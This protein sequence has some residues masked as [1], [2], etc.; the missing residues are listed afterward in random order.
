MDALIQDL[1]YATRS[2]FR[3][4]G[5]TTVAILT[6]TLGVGA[7]TAIFSVADGLI[8]HPLRGVESEGLAIVAV[9]QK[10]P[11]AAADY[12]DWTRLSH[13]FDELAAYRQR[14]ATLTGI[15]QPE[16]VYATEATP[17]FFSVI[18]TET[19]AGR[20]FSN[21]GEDADASVVLSHGFWQRRFG[22]DPHVIG[23][24]VDV[25]GRARTIIGIM[26]K[27]F[28]VPVPT[29]I[30]LPLSLTPADRAKRDA[31]ILRVVGRLK[32]AVTIDAAQTE[33][34]TIGRQ[35][36]ASYPTTNT[37]RRP[38]VM[39]LRE[40]VQGTITR[41]A[42]FLLLSLV[43]VV[44]L[45]ACANVAGLQL[46]RAS[47][48]AREVGLRMALGASRWRVAQ[49]V[50]A[51]T[52][53][54]AIV[55]GAISMIVASFCINLLLRSMPG[56]IARLIPGFTHIRV[57]GRAI[58]FATLVTFASGIVAA[59]AP[60]LRL[61]RT[62]PGESLKESPGSGV[63][64]SR[65]RLRS[66]FVVAQVAVAFVMLVVS[67]L[68]VSGLRGLFRLQDVHD[69]AH[70]LVLSL[71]L[72]SARY[73]DAESR[74][75]F[76]R[77]VVDRFG[78]LP[79]VQL[80][81]SF[82]TIPLSNNGVA[83]AAVDIEG[84]PVSAS[85]PRPNAVVQRVSADY[86]ALMRIP[87]QQG[88]VLNSADRADA[89][90]VV[91]ISESL[92]KRYWPGQDAIGRRVTIGTT[93]AVRWS[94]VVGVV[95]NVLYD[96]TNRVPEPTIYFPV[97]QTPPTAAQIAL[98]V[99]GDPNSFIEPA[100]RE[101]A[102][103][104]PLLPAFDVM[105]LSDAIHQSLVGNP[106]M[107]TMMGMLGGLA[108]IIAVVGL[109]GVISYLVSARTREFGVRLALGARR[110]DIFAVVMLRSASLAAIGI[111]LG[112]LLSIAMSRVVRGVVFGAG[113]S[114]PLVWLEVACVLA[115]VMLFATYVPAHRAMKADPVMALRAE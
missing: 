34:S 68:F 50:L 40:F 109:Y 16:R 105:S 78:S 56:E 104:D 67:T 84:H 32:P 20:V 22:G 88:R 66:V 97:A 108:L 44:L 114:E 99:N 63:A 90:P 69:P 95:G 77:L 28:E 89:T 6:L 30:W 3:S 65:Q 31:L 12:F 23:R 74:E 107:A 80:V 102:A 106:Q 42:M 103:L 72:P 91:V 55:S 10:A 41:A 14:D 100:R 48:R 35:L 87:L 113:N 76:Y 94:I 19:A 45:I 13:S 18:R 61:S 9:G 110:M 57:D 1:R 73:P 83:W 7:N 59:W 52:A 4:P 85:V 26:P 75:R 25:D 27:D 62:Y 96:W 58:W 29:D 37:R 24:P 43:S 53:I 101:L 93:D 112:W 70:V 79:G 17:N 82:S 51:E 54:V 115:F 86:F 81:A 64:A 92:A 38:H 71:N 49:L 8:A 15:D 33:M 47:M 11:A 46:A 98:R 111:G 60:A 39:A 21:S 36:E 2:L 5:F